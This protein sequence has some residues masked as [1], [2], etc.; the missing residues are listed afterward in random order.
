ML[1]HEL[2]RGSL[3]ASNLKSISTPVVSV[4][5]GTLGAVDQGIGIFTMI[6]LKS[7]TFTHR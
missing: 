5:H 4:V 3:S 1:I 2:I 7:N 6:G